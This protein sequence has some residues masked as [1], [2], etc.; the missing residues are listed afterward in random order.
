MIVDAKLKKQ[1]PIEYHGTRSGGIA[2]YDNQSMPIN[3][4]NNYKYHSFLW[5]RLRVFLVAHLALSI[6]FPQCVPETLRPP[7]VPD[8]LWRAHSEQLRLPCSGTKQWMRVSMGLNWLIF[9]WFQQAT[10]TFSCSILHDFTPFFRSLKSHVRLQES[11]ADWVAPGR[12]TKGFSSME[13]RAPLPY[14]ISSSRVSSSC[15]RGIALQRTI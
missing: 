14:A 8:P 9:S 3:E 7:V 10:K 13:P 1:Q 2:H 4:H 15:E 12:L 6:P 11:H 5:R